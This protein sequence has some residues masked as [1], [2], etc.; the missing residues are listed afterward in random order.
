MLPPLMDF[1]LKTE[2]ITCGHSIPLATT[3]CGDDECLNRY[4]ADSEHPD[5][6]HADYQAWQATAPVVE[7]EY[8]DRA[9]AHEELAELESREFIDR[10]DLANIEA[11][12][13][14]LSGPTATA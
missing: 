14:Q 5:Y 10:H 1:S 4:A 13:T 8:H 3:Y 6:S 2:C 11:L 12:R 9:K 7:L